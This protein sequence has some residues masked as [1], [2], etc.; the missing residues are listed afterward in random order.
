MDVMMPINT[1]LKG[2][3]VFRVVFNSAFLL[4]VFFWH[5]V[6]KGSVSTLSSMS[7]QTFAVPT[8]SIYLVDL[9]TNLWWNNYKETFFLGIYFLILT[10]PSFLPKINDLFV[11]C[12]VMSPRS[13][14]YHKRKPSKIFLK[15][16]CMY[17]IY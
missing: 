13:I 17:R 4:I 16:S 10:F 14:H 11:N 1:H 2:V 6:Q 9:C 12:E 5:D 3:L 7:C 8:P 15:K